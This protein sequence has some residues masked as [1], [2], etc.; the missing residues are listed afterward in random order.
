MGFPVRPPAPRNSTVR[1]WRL[2]GTVTDD[3]ER[4][5]LWVQV[6]T[7]MQFNQNQVADWLDAATWQQ[8]RQALGQLASPPLP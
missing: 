6:L 8:R 4:I 7:G 5:R 1:K 3:A 2:P